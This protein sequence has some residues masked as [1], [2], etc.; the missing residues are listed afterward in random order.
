MNL[1]VQENTVT[2]G[3]FP[4]IFSLTK[5][6]ESSSYK[7]A[8]NLFYFFPFCGLFTLSQQNVSFMICSPVCL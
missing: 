7:N 5:C 1:S 6:V 4:L 8:V 2:I 3:S